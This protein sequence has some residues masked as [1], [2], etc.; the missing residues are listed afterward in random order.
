MFSIFFFLVLIDLLKNE[1]VEILILTVLSM[2]TQLINLLKSKEV[3][4]IITQSLKLAASKPV[5]NLIHCITKCVKSLFFIIKTD[6]IT[7]FQKQIWELIEDEEFKN[8]EKP[9]IPATETDNIIQEGYDNQHNTDIIYEENKI[10]DNNNDNNNDIENKTDID[11]NGSYYSP[12]RA[13]DG[14]TS[15]F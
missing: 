14:L 9:N 12:V 11:D 15:M 8:A 4:I 1:H 7:K 13:W 6:E 5:T 2:L 3:Q 10:D